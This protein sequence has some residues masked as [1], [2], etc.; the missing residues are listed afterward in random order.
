MDKEAGGPDRPAKPEIRTGRIN[1]LVGV[2]IVT[3]KEQ[4]GLLTPGYWLELFIEDNS[5]FG[6]AKEDGI[7][8]YE[9]KGH[10]SMMRLIEGGLEEIAKRVEGTEIR[11]VFG[12]SKIPNLMT[13]LG[14]SVTE[15]HDTQN[16]KLTHV[17]SISAE[18]LR[19]RPWRETPIS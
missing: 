7:K 11:G 14:F 15:A 1:A 12:R 18:A 16:P 3:I 6:G 10:A 17:A 8:P 9:S 4:R 2:D 5:R 19:V 13:R